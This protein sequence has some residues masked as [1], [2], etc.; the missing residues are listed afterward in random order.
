MAEKYTDA[1]IQALGEKG[2][3]FKNPDGSY[4]YPI[5]DD[6][7][8]DNAIR[9]VGRGNADHDAI[10]KYI[11][12]RA[13][14]LGKSDDIP[15]NWNKDGS[16]DETK[17]TVL[18]YSVEG[19]SSRTSIVHTV[20]ELRYEFYQDL[21]DA[22]NNALESAY[23]CSQS[24]PT[25]PDYCD[26]W[27][28]DFSS[29][30]VI[31]ECWA[32]GPGPG[33]WCQSYSIDADG[34]VTLGDDAH[35]VNSHTTYEPIPDSEPQAVGTNAN[36]GVGSALARSKSSKRNGDKERHRAGP[37]LPREFRM[38]VSHGLEVR[39][40]VTADPNIL[41]VTG[42]PITYGV[43]YEVND[44]F[45]SFNETMH[46]GV[47]KD[48]LSAQNLDVRFLFNHDG[49]PLGRTTADTLAL[50]ETDSGLQCA[51]QL[52]TRQGL[53]ND[54]AIAIERGDV[55][56][57]SVGFVVKRDK[58]SADYSTRDI[59]SI[60]ELF[61]VSA[62]TYPASP[63][64]SI[65]IGQ[66]MWDQVPIESRARVRR[67]WA[68]TKDLRAG[69]VL[70]AAN[71]DLLQNAFDVLASV[72]TDGLAAGTEHASK[73]TAAKTNLGAVLA[74]ATPVTLDNDGTSSSTAGSDGAP[75]VRFDE[76]EVETPEAPRKETF[77]EIQKRHVRERADRERQAKLNNIRRKAA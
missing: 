52:D 21:R 31:Y 72:D 44:M 8:L 50:Q 45:G 7:D 6:E 71:A 27:V 33:T 17:A 41:V 62:V 70:S 54:L 37:D 32:G 30:E 14:D 13:E 2:H 58:W 3:A 36:G 12:G 51:V 19:S 73:I 29:N 57:M 48:V 23:P 40:N 69:K 24:D 55:N 35:Q 10:R 61:D 38:F 16:L 43:P 18:T 26:V 9:A 25:L 47:C 74:A 11:M 76:E 75:S 1:E 4:S 67:V 20:A 63:T 22:L 42:T 66:R 59:F 56:Q 68:V 77:A 46:R 39:E 34:N 15:E 60:K 53:A 28:C 65:E 64:T 49:L 5:D